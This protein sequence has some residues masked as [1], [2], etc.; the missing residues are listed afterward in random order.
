MLLSPELGPELV[1][2]EPQSYGPSDQA[3]PL[4]MSSCTVTITPPP[5]PPPPPGLAVISLAGT[6]VWRQLCAHL[7]QL[8]VA[9][10]VCFFSY[11]CCFIH[12]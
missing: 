2:M 11:H 1:S 12:R 6:W 7:E 4:S 8:D 5:P 10:L 9:L 3:F